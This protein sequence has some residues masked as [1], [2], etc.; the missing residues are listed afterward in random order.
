MHTHMHTYAHT[1]TCACRSSLSASP[2][3]R[4]V[5]G[6]N[7]GFRNS[8][9]MDNEWETQKRNQTQSK[10]PKNVTG[11]QTRY[12]KTYENINHTSGGNGTGQRLWYLVRFHELPTVIP[13]GWSRDSK[14]P[15]KLSLQIF[16]AWLATSMRES[17]CHR[18]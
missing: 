5:D 10:R 6:V 18:V 12:V 3:L 1:C 7:K 9:G 11:N 17:T 14:M 8:G 15:P 4:H 16:E 2:N 13:N